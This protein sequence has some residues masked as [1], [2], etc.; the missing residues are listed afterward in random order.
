MPAPVQRGTWPIDA[1]TGLADGD[2]VYIAIVT[3]DAD[4]PNW[5]LSGFTSIF[6]QQ[7]GADP[8]WLTILRGTISG[9][10]PSGFTPTTGATLDFWHAT[11]IAYSGVDVANEVVGTS[12]NAN[13][14]G[15]TP[16]TIPGITVTDDESL[17]VAFTAERYGSVGISGWTTVNSADSDIYSL[18]FDAGATGGISATWTNGYQPIIAVLVSVPPAAVVADVPERPVGYR[19]PRTVRVSSQRV[20]AYRRRRR[21]RQGGLL[22]AVTPAAA[23]LTPDGFSGRR[24]RATLY[25]ARRTVRRH[26]AH[27]VS[28]LRRYGAFFFDEGGAVDAAV[29]GTTVATPVSVPA[30]SV[31]SSST[32]SAGVVAAIVAVPVPAVSG[33]AASSASVVAVTVTVPAATVSA[34][35]NATAS[36]AVVEATVTVPV[37]AVS[38]S[39]AVTATTVTATI[40]IPA[41]TVSASAGA[42]TAGR[43]TLTVDAPSVSVTVSTLDVLSAGPILDES[44]EPILDESGE[45]ILD[46]TATSPP[47]GTV[48]VTVS[49]LDVLSGGPILDESGDPILD[50]SGDPI[51]TSHPAGTVTV[52]TATAAVTVT[53]TAAQVAISIGEVP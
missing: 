45:P 42:S 32:A 19:S 3:E 9:T 52:T 47:V 11:C 43:V 25:G 50:E 49:T 7:R 4:D 17:V 2:V 41:P 14:L 40:T 8:Y 34:S 35:S 39:A 38:G 23:P 5:S 26:A 15:T 6:E 12:Y 28:V 24:R 10:P 37:P 13:P 21:D 16:I 31:A 29:T 46:E 22:P 1:P 44:G 20:V 33:S 51:G 18:E 36:P 27:N 53:A 30:A 48:T